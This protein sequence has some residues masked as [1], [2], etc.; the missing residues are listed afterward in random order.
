M[1]T[2]IFTAALCTELRNV[3]KIIRPA[4]KPLADHRDYI[5]MEDR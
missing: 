1:R 4:Y 3:D 2:W 5:R